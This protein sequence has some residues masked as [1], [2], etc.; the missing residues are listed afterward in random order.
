MM[1]GMNLFRDEYFVWIAVRFGLV[2]LAV[3]VIIGE[4]VGGEPIVTTEAG[5]RIMTNEGSIFGQN[6]EKGKG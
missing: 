1:D 6:S 2:G 3:L 4:S 5:T